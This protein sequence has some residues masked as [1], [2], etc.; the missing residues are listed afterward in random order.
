MRN[1]YL[2]AMYLFASISSVASPVAPDKAR[3]QALNFLQTKGI[4]IPAVNAKKALRLSAKIEQATAPYYIYNVEG[5]KGFVVVAGDDRV[6]SI[7]GYG[8][9]GSLD[10]ENLPANVEHFLEGYAAQIKALGSSPVGAKKI[11]DINKQKQN[12]LIKT[13]WGQ[14]APYNNALDEITVDG[15]TYHL[16]VGCVGVATAQV[17]G[18]YKYPD[19]VKVTIPAYTT[20]SKVAGQ[21]I[22][23]PDVQSGTTIDWQN[24]KE[25]YRG[26]ETPAQTDAVAKFMKISATAVCTQFSTTG[27][28]AYTGVVPYALRKYFGYSNNMRYVSRSS[29]SAQQW[30]DLLYDEIA[31]GRPVIIGGQGYSGGHEFIAD[32]YDGDGLFHINW[33]WCGQCNGYFLLSALEPGNN[34]DAGVGTTAGAYNNSVEAIIGIAPAQEGEA[35]PILKMDGTV[36]SYDADAKTVKLLFYNMTGATGSFDYGLGYVNK[37]G[38]TVVLNS[39]SNESFEFNYGSYYTGDVSGLAVGTYKLRP[40]SRIHGQKTWAVD[41]DYVTATID[42]NH[43][44]KFTRDTY[45]LSTK[46]F[47]HLGTKTAGVEQQLRVTIANSGAEY[48]GKLYLTAANSSGYID[49]VGASV[50]TGDSTVVTFSFLPYIK[51]TFRMRVC[52]DSYGNEVIGETDVEIGDSAAAVRSLR[53]TGVKIEHSTPSEI[54]GVTD[55][56]GNWL[57]GTFT[58]RNDEATSFTGNL[59]AYMYCGA[60]ADGGFWG[61]GQYMEPVFINSN[62]TYDMKFKFDTE[63]SLYYI[64]SLMYDDGTSFG[65]TDIAHMLG[66]SVDGISQAATAMPAVSQDAMV[67]TL[68]GVCLG[69]MEHVGTLPKG[70]YIVD[71][72]KIVRQ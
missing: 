26:N 17:M 11:S 46:S 10:S 27:S 3:Q 69:T 31:A 59:V 33:G 57:Q 36:N 12:P 21:T 9:T 67:Y 7:L 28:G 58:I 71:G 64:V 32:G 4:S 34:Y 66:G 19:T 63:K 1:V 70:I 40:V 35:E 41:S 45:K 56:Q 47:K 43:K 49:V 60:S 22:T 5:E 44:V 55:V 18:Y 52:T 37:N 68:S 23:L 72:K 61:S 14:K 54:L 48:N 24:I 13:L 25:I 42:K 29:Y 65:N 38:K 2:I 51:S 6:P 20:P 50:P 16:Y 39:K 53:L 62:N 8:D 15:S 30:T